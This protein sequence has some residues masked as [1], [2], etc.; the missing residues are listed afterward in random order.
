M[1]ALEFSICIASS[2]YYTQTKFLFIF[3]F[4]KFCN[5]QFIASEDDINAAFRNSFSENNLLQVTSR[6]VIF[7][8]CGIVSFPYFIYYAVHSAYQFVFRDFVRYFP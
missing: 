6:L 7:W 4:S 2:I 8:K 1:I 5:N 3:N